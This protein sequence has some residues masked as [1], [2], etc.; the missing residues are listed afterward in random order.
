MK[1]ELLTF[2]DWVRIFGVERLSD[3]CHVTPRAVY[4]WMAGSSKP[5]LPR[6]EKILELA[7]RNLTLKSITGGSK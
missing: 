6:C 5:S 2:A 3:E 4:G 7:G 1:N